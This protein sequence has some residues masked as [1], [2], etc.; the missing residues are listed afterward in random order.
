MSRRS[1]NLAAASLVI[2]LTWLPFSAVR[3]VELGPSLVGAT[4]TEQHVLVTGETPNRLAVLDG[5]GSQLL[6]SVDLPGRPGLP[7]STRKGTEV[8]IP[9]FS[10]GEV[11]SI[12]PNTGE[13]Q[14]SV[15][16]GRGPKSASLDPSQKQLYV[17]NSLDS[18]VSVVD[19]RSRAVIATIPT[20][21]NPVAVT[22]H[23]NRAR[24]YVANAGSGDITIVN[25]RRM[26]AMTT[27]KACGL[28]LRP[29]LSASGK[30]AFISCRGSGTV[31]VIDTTRNALARIIPV[32]SKP[33]PPAL[34]RDAKRLFVPLE[35]EAA[36]SVIQLPSGKVTGKV[37]VGEAPTTATLNRTGR[38]LFVPNRSGA[39]VSV[40]NV[41]RL[42]VTRTVPTQPSPVQVV[43]GAR[44]L[45][46]TESGSVTEIPEVS[47][48]EEMTPPE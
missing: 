14:W 8:F 22:V 18:T 23:P 6:T 32:G 47:T 10:T 3:A 28:P 40:V 7:V 25:T 13:R 29:V 17:P 15:K 1:W 30:R 37:S 2:G 48:T 12:D 46:I 26:R 45:V 5:T 19:I 27:L 4:T 20:G 35:G 31:A 38:L 21:S 39:T 42:Q 44:P 24:A 33:A 11:V 34:T 41:N 43:I 16:V 9:I 36:V